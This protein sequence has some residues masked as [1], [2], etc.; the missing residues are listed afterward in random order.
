MALNTQILSSRGAL[1][2]FI[3]WVIL[4]EAAL[5]VAYAPVNFDGVIGVVV[6]ISPEV[7]EI[8]AASAL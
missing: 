6:D 7:Y 5:C 8:V 3:V 1:A 4:L 2:R